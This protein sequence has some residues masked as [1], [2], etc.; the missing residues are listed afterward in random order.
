MRPLIP[1]SQFLILQ[2]YSPSGILSCIQIEILNVMFS[3]A[4]KPH[5]V[6]FAL[7]AQSPIPCLPPWRFLLNSANA[8]FPIKPSLTSPRL[9]L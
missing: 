1:G 6:P 4:C 3:Q 2:V 9:C 7:T 5:V 8:T